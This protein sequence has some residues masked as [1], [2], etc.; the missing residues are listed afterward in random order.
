VA[1]LVDVYGGYLERERVRQLAE[2]ARRRKLF[3]QGRPAAALAGRS[4]IVADDAVT[5]GSTLIAALR[6][7][8]AAGPLE[9]IA[10]VPVAPAGRLDEIRPYC[11]EIV[12]LH[13]PAEARAA[14]DF[15]DDYPPVSDAEALALFSGSAPEEAV[16]APPAEVGA[17]DPYP[18]D[19]E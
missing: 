16:C 4:V 2:I 13:A 5:T 19:D 15:Y 12:C 3:R 1:L 18:F 11:D 17:A 7:A 9:L 10:A 6:G 8:R 14:A